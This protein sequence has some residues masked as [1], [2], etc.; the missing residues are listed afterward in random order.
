MEKKPDETTYS[1]S[2]REVIALMIKAAGITEGKWTMRPSFKTRGG[3]FG[4]NDDDMVPGF[5]TV[6]NGYKLIEAD[7]D[8]S[9]SLVVDAQEVHE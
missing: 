7:E 3:N 6:I 4:P 8:D 1:Y 5:F 9:S 2:N